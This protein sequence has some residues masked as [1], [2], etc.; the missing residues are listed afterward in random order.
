MYMPA[1]LELVRWLAV[2]FMKFSNVTEVIQ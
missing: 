1:V 2:K